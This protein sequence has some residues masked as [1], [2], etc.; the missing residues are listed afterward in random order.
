MAKL[1]KLTLEKQSRAVSAFLHEPDWLLQKRLEAVALLE[2]R[3]GRAEV[4]G[5]KMDRGSMIVKT[6]CEGNA[7]VL[8]IGQALKKGNALREQ[9]EKPFTGNEPDSYLLSFALFTDANVVAIGAEGRSRASVELSGKPP[10]YFATFFLFADRSDSSVFVEKRLAASANECLCA[11]VGND[12]R[13]QICLLQQ[14]GKT[15]RNETGTVASLGKKTRLKI[16]ESN[17]GGKEH[18]GQTVILQNGRGSRC[19]NYEICM[20]KGAQKFR[21][22]MKHL[23]NASETY[24]RSVFKCASSGKSRVNMD[25]NVIVGREARGADTHFLVKGLLLQG[26]PVLRA[27]PRLS[28]QNSDVAAGHGTAIAPI[29]EDELFYL[30]SR[31]IDENESRRL[32]LQGFLTDALVKSGMDDW[33]LEGVAREIEKDARGAFAGE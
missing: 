21:K 6:E 19:E 17:L 1:A 2:R 29:D 22:D 13:A 27:V 4:S 9:I 8:P 25:G 5:F 20:A 11:I 12:A 31:G 18:C 7:F 30:R 10:E 33:I 15:S 28:V 14:N 26:K 32:V 24:S 3:R 16:L 23:H